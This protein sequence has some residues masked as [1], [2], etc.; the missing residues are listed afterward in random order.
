MLNIHHLQTAF[1]CVKHHRSPINKDVVHRNDVRETSIN[2]SQTPDVRFAQK[3]LRLALTHLIHTTTSMNLR[4]LPCNLKDLS[5]VLIAPLNETSRTRFDV[6]TEQLRPACLLKE[7]SFSVSAEPL[8]KS[9]R[10]PV[11]PDTQA[12]SSPSERLGLRGPADPN[13]RA[14][15]SILLGPRILMRLNRQ[16]TEYPQQKLEKEA[17]FSWLAPAEWPTSLS[18]CGRAAAWRPKRSRLGPLQPNS[19]TR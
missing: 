5:E 14:A 16:L 10:D 15:D 18:G 11:N 6:L 9:I 7:T 3:L 1:S 2:C 4:D 12:I 17:S 13:L 8:R 19:H